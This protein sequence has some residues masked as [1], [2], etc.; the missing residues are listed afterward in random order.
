MQ[1]C[2]VNSNYYIEPVIQLHFTNLV[3]SALSEKQ[4]QT[5]KGC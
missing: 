5:E 2:K 1:H 4:S 3:Y